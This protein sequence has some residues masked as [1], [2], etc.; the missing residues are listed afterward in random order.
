MNPGE[1][2]T[3]D[4]SLPPAKSLQRDGL[5]TDGAPA[6]C[7]SAEIWQCYRQSLERSDLAARSLA[8]LTLG[9]GLVL[10]GSALLCDGKPQYLPLQAAVG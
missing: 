8:S 6:Y 4:A 3:H 9:F 10:C 5:S 7:R 1:N 2:V